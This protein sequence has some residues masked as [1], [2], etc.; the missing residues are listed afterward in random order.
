M[1]RKFDIIIIIINA[2]CGSA[3]HCTLFSF[4]L[5]VSCLVKHN[6]F[7]QLHFVYIVGKKIEEDDDMGV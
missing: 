3:R 6:F 4:F 1:H 5:C 2:L 7:S